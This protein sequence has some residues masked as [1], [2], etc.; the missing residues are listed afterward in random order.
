ME[1][2]PR[3]LFRGALCFLQ[4]SF[5]V[6]FYAQSFKVCRSVVRFSFR[7]PQLMN[8]DVLFL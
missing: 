5:V 7:H 2:V 4:P 8:G 3:R 6:C 1:V